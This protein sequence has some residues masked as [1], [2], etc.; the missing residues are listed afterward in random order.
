MGRNGKISAKRYSIRFYNFKG[1]Y[2]VF[3]YKRRGWIRDNIKLW[4]FV[5]APPYK[6]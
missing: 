4:L 3:G 1:V 2:R 5:Y 6:R